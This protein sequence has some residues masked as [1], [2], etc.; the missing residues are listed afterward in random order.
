M[1]E[2]VVET[3]EEYDLIV[4]GGGFSGIGAAYQFFQID[5]SVKNSSWRGDIQTRFSGPHLYINGFW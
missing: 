4:V 5:G 2:D 3:D 1:L